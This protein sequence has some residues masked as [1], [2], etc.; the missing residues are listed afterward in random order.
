ML[1]HLRTVVVNLPGSGNSIAVGI[2]WEI[3]F[4]ERVSTA[5]W[6]L[7]AVLPRWGRMGFEGGYHQDQNST[8][9]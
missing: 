9:R 7:C 4:H 2:G 6:G 5:A 8:R 1:D 3:R